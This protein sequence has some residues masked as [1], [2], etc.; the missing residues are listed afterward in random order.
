MAKGLHDRF[1]VGDKYCNDGL[2][3]LLAVDDH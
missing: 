1:G 2:L 3:F